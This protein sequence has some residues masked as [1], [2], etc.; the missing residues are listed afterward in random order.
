MARVRSGRRTGRREQAVL[1]GRGGKL[2]EARAEDEP[3][4]QVAG[5]QPVVLER[6]REPVRGRAREAGR[7]NELREGRRTGFECTKDDGRLV[8]NA[9]SARLVHAM[10]LTSQSLRRKFIGVSRWANLW[11]AGI[12]PT[13][14]RVGAC[15]G[16]IR[17]LGGVCEL[18]T[19]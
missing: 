8:K 17:V 14:L 19:T 3:A 10:I 12:R 13:R 18:S 7:G 6:H 11:D 16:V 2:D 4:L 5:H 1:S 9:D 15:S